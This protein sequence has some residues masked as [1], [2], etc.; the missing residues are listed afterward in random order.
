MNRKDT[1]TTQ[2]PQAQT[3][4]ARAGDAT[5]TP[6]GKL[7][8]VAETRSAGKGMLTQDNPASGAQPAPARGERYSAGD[9]GSGLPHER[10]QSSEM[11]AARPDPVVEQAAKDLANGMSDTSK[12]AETNAAYKKLK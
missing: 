11:T 1:E 9:P 10:D 12:G 6:T 2:Q 7:N 4:D 3:P 5:Q 8:T